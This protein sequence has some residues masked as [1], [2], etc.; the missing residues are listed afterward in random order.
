MTWAWF[1]EGV[2]KQV[3]ALIIHSLLKN[4]PKPQSPR[5]LTI[6][7]LGIGD[8]T[9]AGHF[10][11]RAA[12]RWD[13]IRP[14]HPGSHSVLDVTRSKVETLEKMKEANLLG[15]VLLL[16]VGVCRE[17]HLRIGVIEVL[18][19]EK[20]RKFILILHSLNHSSDLMVIMQRDLLLTLWQRHRKWLTSAMNLSKVLTTDTALTL[21]LDLGTVNIKKLNII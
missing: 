3:L 10:P 15:L 17:N 13:D 9:G 6:L 1:T 4:Q 2:Q 16:D 5:S 20:K 19:L 21:A 11:C 14:P 7:S 8:N 12:H 18:N